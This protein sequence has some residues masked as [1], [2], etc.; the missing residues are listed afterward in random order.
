ME[1]KDETKRKQRISERVFWRIFEIFLKEEQESCSL[2]MQTAPQRVCDIAEIAK[3][4]AIK[5]VDSYTEKLSD[6]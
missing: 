3:E 5:L 2:T 6:G 1:Q 4:A